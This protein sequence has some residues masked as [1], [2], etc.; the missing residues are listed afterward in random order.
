M[1][2]PIQNLL[3]FIDNSPSSYHAVQS[4][5]NQLNVFSDNN[6]LARWQRLNEQDSWQLKTGGC[7]YVVRDDSSIIM[8]MLGEKPLIETGFKI[9]AAHTDSPSLRLKP[10]P[11]STSD[12]LLRLGVEIY[13]G[14]ILATFTDRDLSL[15]GRISYKEEN[16]L[17]HQLIHFKKP[18]IRLPNLAIHLNRGVNDDGLKLQKQNELPL[19]LSNITA[20]QLPR[21]V[22]LNLLA[23]Q[24]NIQAEQILSWDLNI[25]DT[26]KGSIWGANNE[27][28]ANSQLDNLASCHA[29]LTA[30]L[31]QEV[32]NSQNNLICAFFDHEEIG[33]ESSKGA[34]GNFLITILQRIM[35]AQAL[36]YE[37]SARIL[38]NSFLI[39]ADMAHAY[40][41]NFPLAYEPEHKVYVNQ[42]VVIK[43]NHNHRYSTDNISTAQF[44]HWC[45]QANVPYQHYVQRCDMACG[46]TVGPMTA[47][48]LGIRA[49]DVGCPMWA[50][51]SVRESAGVIDHDYM[52]RVMR[53]FFIN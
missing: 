30:L 3:N 22:F 29:G 42:G 13:G 41:P 40:Q 6:Q 27:F 49:I 44:I 25:Y 15:A 28:Y 9:I 14:P 11:A 17:K 16:S 48:K 24:V 34:D 38:A 7:Y 36:T 19:I 5:I 53:Q 4:I 45:Q 32:F 20:E 43:T 18:L 39:S 10:N 23:Q 35:Q 51:H 46:S 21:D 12:N 2:Q 37:D 31:N 8:F 26:Q 47:A 52:I 50:M 1:N 33:S